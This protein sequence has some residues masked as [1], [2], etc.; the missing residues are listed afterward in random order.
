MLARY[1]GLTVVGTMAIAVAIALGTTYFE[2]VNK[3]KNPLLPVSDAARL[4]SVLNWDFNAS[5]PEARSLHDFAMW[6]DQIKTI[7]GL[8]AAVVFV[9]N[10]VT[11]D[12][13]V[14]PV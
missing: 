11:E 14:E 6:R 1:P 10:L 2:A 4:V 8:G 7:G 5:R 9:R 13:R 12:G 3:L